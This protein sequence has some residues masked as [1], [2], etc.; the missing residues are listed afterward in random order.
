MSQI[1]RTWTFWIFAVIEDECR[2]DIERMVLSRMRTAPGNR[3]ASALFNNAGDGT[4]EVVVL[5]I[6]DG[7]QPIVVRVDDNTDRLVRIVVRTGARLPRSDSAQGK[8]FLAFGPD[9]AELSGDE[10]RSIAATRVAVNSQV[11]EGIRA[12]RHRAFGVQY[13]PEAGPGPGDARYLF[14]E[15]AAL[16]DGREG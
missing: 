2:D 5:S 16:I 6:W 15:F 9:A 8:V 14:D 4:V 1:L 11:V 10:R 13:H 7:E 12:P 3:R